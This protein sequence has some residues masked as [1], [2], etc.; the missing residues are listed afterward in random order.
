ML[1]PHTL[2]RRA[3]LGGV[4]AAGLVGISACSSSGSSGGQVSYGT[5]GG[6]VED[7]AWKPVFDT[8][9]SDPARAG[10]EY[11]ALGGNYG[12]EY[13][14]K[15]QTLLT[16]GDAPDV[17]YISEDNLGSYAESGAIVPI[18]E[19]VQAAGLSLDGF[20][21]SSVKACTY[22]GK[23]YGLPRDGA[24]NVLWYNADLFDRAR[25][26]YPDAEWTWSDYLAAATELTRRDAG[27]R[28]IQLGADRG[29]WAS[30]VWQAGGNILNEDKTSCLLAESAAVDGLQFAQ[31]LVVKHRVAPSPSD[32]GNA[33]TSAAGQAIQQMFQSGRLAMYVSVRG[34]LGA[35]CSSKFRFAAAPLPRG[36]LRAV[37]ALA[38]PTVLNGKAE[39]KQRAFDL[40]SFIC[41]DQGQE[42]KIKSGYAYPSRRALVTQDWYKDFRCGSAVDA[43]INTAFTHQM[44]NGWTRSLPTHARWP[45]ILS[46][47]NKGLDALFLGQKSAQQVGADTA[48]AVNKLLG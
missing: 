15:L 14:Q 6:D 44:E 22:N 39:D 29:D 10:A 2:S 18:E 23:L 43:S 41:S 36:K 34:S 47:I 28:A 32:L 27:G 31:D 24:P 48:A 17:F 30:W 26:R 40:M 20:W 35:I 8:F 38:G 42:L 1:Q 46:E 45:Q 5:P 25:V 3:L 11:R 7:K 37:R 21:P 4:V 12:P 19:Y 33:S 13:Y 9:N 16:S